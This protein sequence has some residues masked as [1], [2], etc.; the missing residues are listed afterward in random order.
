MGLE[1]GKREPTSQESLFAKLVGALLILM[2]VYAVGNLIYSVTTDEDIQTAIDGPD[3]IGLGAEV[4]LIDPQPNVTNQ[5]RFF[6]DVRLNQTAN[7][8]GLE[9]GDLLVKIGDV[10]LNPKTQTEDEVAGIFNQVFTQAALDGQTSITIE[11]ARYGADIVFDTTEPVG[12]VVAFDLEVPT[13][14]N[15]AVASANVLELQFPVEVDLRDEFAMSVDY[16]EP[17]EIGS[18]Y[19][20]YPASDGPSS[21][22][23]DGSQII[24]IDDD[25]I[26]PATHTL[27]EVKTLA[28]DEGVALS[29]ED[30]EIE[31]EY[32]EFLKT[33]DEPRVVDTKI[34][35]QV[36]PILFLALIDTFGF[37]VPF[38]TFFLAFAFAKV[39]L[40]IFKYDISAAR[41]ALVIF[42]WLVVGLV[43]DGARLFWLGGKGGSF[44]NTDPFD[45]GEA[46]TAIVPYLIVSIPMIFS[47]FW[48]SSVANDIFIGEEN[49][50]QR[51]NRF[52]WTLLVPTLAILT[53]V[54]AR[55]LEQTFVKSLT[56]E[57]FGTSRPSRFVGLDNYEK[58]LTFRIVTVDC[59]L[60][61][62]ANGNEVCARSSGV[63]EKIQWDRSYYESADY[64]KDTGEIRFQEAFVIGKPFQGDDD[65]KQTAYKIIAKDSE[66]IQGFVN[67]VHFALIAVTL[68]LLLGLI[69]ALVVNTQFAGR[70]LMRTAMLVPW[71][72]PT[73]VSAALWEVI[74]RPDQTGIA[75]KF[76]LDVG[77]VSENQAWLIETGPWMNS[78]IAVDVWKTSPFMALL[79]LA[80]LQTI[81]GDLYEAA[82][83]DGAG[84]IRQFFSI[85][86][87]LLRP[88]I[89][90]A[91][92]FRTLDSLRVF[93][94]FQVLLDPTR[95]SMAT[96]N[97]TTLVD[98]QREAGYAS[99]IGVLIFLFILIFTVIYVRFVGIENE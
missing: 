39:G 54:A 16:L 36:A 47:Y 21:E 41:W 14:V 27:D 52:A 22:I 23:Q 34:N 7:Q 70:G 2:A 11:V 61:E 59:K 8:L 43:I 89:A 79:I 35:K 49:L 51:N 81:P 72:I 29:D 33:T 84:K 64:T 66:F 77:L 68:E 94:V 3:H 40:G 13:D 88:T 10:E 97:F 83:V 87:P 50:T 45:L 56:D 75:N 85:T 98:G 4:R 20:L 5:E 95:P 69:I 17:L 53:L 91:L 44:L 90:V 86:L 96:Y 48:L 30:F 74:L 55:P 28:L 67:T 25:E 78:I 38:L 37:V 1:Y 76:L 58:L 9:D 80:G 46:I 26:S 12:E 92:V 62:D 18:F 15:E 6:V 19:A 65:G 71:A 99:A 93:D 32:A 60:D 82:S 42:M 73:V 31:L 24:R 57:T 63:K